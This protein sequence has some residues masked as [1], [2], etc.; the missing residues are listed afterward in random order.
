[1]NTSAA[2]QMSK[3]GRSPDSPNT[4]AALERSKRSRIDIDLTLQLCTLCQT[5]DLDASFDNAYKYYEQVKNGSKAPDRTRHRTSDG[6]HFYNDAVFVHRFDTRLSSA[7]NCQLCLFFQ[8]LRVQPDLHKRHKL[9]AFRSSDSWLFREDRLSEC[10]SNTESMKI[11]VDTVFMA[12]VPD[13]ESISLSGHE[14]KWL[15][16][17]IPTVGAIFRRPVDEGGAGESNN[18]LSARE[19]D[20][21]YDLDRVRIWL[22]TCRRE[23]GDACKQRASQEPISRGFRL[24]DCTQ[25]PPVVEEKPWGT[26]YTALSYVWGSTPADLVD[27]PKTVLDAI[28]VTKELGMKYLWVDRLC[29][30]QSDTGEK[31]YLISRMT[32]IYEE[33]DFTIVAAAGEG[34]SHG[35]PGVRYTPRT[36]QPKYYLDSGSL[37]LSILRDPRRDILE[38]QYWTRGWTYQEGV[39]ANR[40]VVFTDSQTYWECRCMATHESADIALF[41]QK[42]D[43]NFVMADFMLTGIFKGGAYSGGSLAHQD[44]LVID[45][46][47]EYRLDYGF[48]TIQEMT[49]GA[50]LRGL[51]E[52]IRAFSKRRLTHDTDILLAFQG[53]V[54][55]YEQTKPLCLLHGLPMWTGDIAGTA[56]GAQ[57]T[58]ALSVSSWYHRASPHY[59]IFVSEPCQRRTHLP[60][61]T[62][63]GWNGTVTWRAP[64]NLEH[65]SYMSDMIFA[66]SPGITW[67]ANIYLSHPDRASALRL[68]GAQSAAQ[69]ALESFTTMEIRDPFILSSFYRVENKNK[70]WSWHPRIGRPGREQLS[71][72][73]PHWVARWYRIGR[74]LAFIGMSVAMTGQQWTDQHVSGDLVSVLMFAGRYWGNEHGTAR[75]LTLRR[76]RSSPERWERVGTLYLIIPFLASCRHSAGLFAKIP[77]RKRKRC[78]VIQ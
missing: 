19:F 28:E 11:Y 69:L 72:D 33:A 22:D 15:D 13:V 60:S 75:F 26:E 27:W 68:L 42:K 8:S 31:S 9:L 73:S 52:H 76:V 30:N 1:M 14:V 39:L 18:L 7:S 65:C 46:D 29:I 5:L 56:A 24:I 20:D 57:V 32:T 55:L 53:V 17:E 41:H 6:R 35:L 62:W 78:I 58:F 3:R 63:A 43:H 37:L 54:G 34:A 38:S 50:Q 61:W 44:N 21:K 64:P 12:V 51:D 40:R 67:A 4:E 74:R 47:E 45:V 10:Q 70:E 48:P 66:T 77:A 23:H 59:S 71:T 25:N 49:V 16:Y 36:P 2:Y